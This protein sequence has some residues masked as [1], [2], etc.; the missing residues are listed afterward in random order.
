MGSR[1][2]AAVGGRCD[3]KGITRP[4]LQHRSGS[5]CYLPPPF[6]PKEHADP[7]LQSVVSFLLPDWSPVWVKVHQHCQKF[8][9]CF[10]TSFS[11]SD[12]S[13]IDQQ[14]ASNRAAWSRLEGLSAVTSF[15]FHFNRFRE[16][17]DETSNFNVLKR[18]KKH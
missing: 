7:L 6:E 11:F 18:Q 12:S 10:L 15:Q 4:A 3:H 8:L 16:I 2:T 17:A 5:Y 13:I 9:N 1:I 14:E